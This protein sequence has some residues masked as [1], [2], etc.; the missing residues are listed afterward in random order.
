MRMVT[1][2]RQCAY[3]VRHCAEPKGCCP[4]AISRGGARF[5]GRWTVL[6]TAEPRNLPEI[7]RPVDRAARPSVLAHPIGVRDR[8]P[9]TTTE[10]TAIRVRGLRKSYQGTP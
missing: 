5:V 1:P 6:W 8:L 10:A 9:M 7:N 2:Q 4:V 3:V